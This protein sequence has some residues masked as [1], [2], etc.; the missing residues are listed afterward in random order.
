MKKL[1]WIRTQ[2]KRKKECVVLMSLSVP[3]TFV[4][5]KTSAIF[6]V[7]FTIDSTIPPTPTILTRST[8]IVDSSIIPMVDISTSNTSVSSST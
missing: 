6:L 3:P 2:S 4:V 5:P 7:Q 8:P 1:K